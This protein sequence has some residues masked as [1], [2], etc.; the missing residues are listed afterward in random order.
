MAPECLQRPTNSGLSRPTRHDESP[1]NGA[2]C[3]VALSAVP[4]R[5]LARYGDRGTRY[6]HIEAGHVI[7]N[8][9]LTACTL[10]L[11]GVPVGSFEDAAVSV[12]IELS[13][14][15]VPLYVVPIGWPSSPAC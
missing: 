3:I 4:S 11:V 14:N 13:T 5:T 6:I 1:R 10:G 2:P 8:L 7:Q 15:E 9:L 12:V